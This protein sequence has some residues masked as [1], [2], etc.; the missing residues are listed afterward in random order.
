MAQKRQERMKAR[1]A[2]LAALQSDDSEDED[3][4][5]VHSSDLEQS[6]DADQLEQ[7]FAQFGAAGVDQLA[8]IADAIKELAAS[9]LASEEFGASQRAAKMRHAAEG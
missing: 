5:W 3:D 9:V 4:V 8:D 2:Q 1:Q 7:T 6:I